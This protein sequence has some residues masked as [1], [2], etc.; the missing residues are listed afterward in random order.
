MAGDWI[1]FEKATSD[2]PEVWAVAER[3]NLDPDAV[4]GKLLRVWAWFDDH[5]ENGASPTARAA[6]LDRMVGTNGFCEAMQAAGWL[7]TDGDSVALPNFD[8]HN[9]ATAKKR[10]NGAKRAADHRA[11]R[12]AGVTQRS[13]DDSGRLSIPRPV[14]RSVMQRDGAKCVYCGRKDGEYAHGETSRDGIIS[15]DHVIPVCHGGSNEINN[16][17]CACM[18]C[19]SFKG[20]RTPDEC[21]LEWPKMSDGKRYGS[22]TSALPREEKRR[23]E[24]KTKQSRAVALPNDMQP[25]DGHKALAESLGVTLIT[26]F[27]KFCDHHK[28]K[29]ST[30]KDWNAALNNWLRNAA[31]FQAERGPVTPSGGAPRLKEFRP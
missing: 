7:E 10:A 14:R 19:N 6:M 28:A 8:K 15:I 2:K 25:S 3:L 20:D 22:V 21:G 1:K 23:E 9:G 27:E 5:T 12:N 4:V 26:E 30:F 17:V 13:D 24:K 18:S 31:K 16:L 29:G 11:K